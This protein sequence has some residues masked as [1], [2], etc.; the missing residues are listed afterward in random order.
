MDRKE[1]SRGEKEVVEKKGGEKTKPGKK[2]I[3]NESTIR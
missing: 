1:F 2:S 3:I